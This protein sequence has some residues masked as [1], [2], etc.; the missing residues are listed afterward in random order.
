MKKSFGKPDVTQANVL[1]RCGAVA[2]WLKMRFGIPYI[3]VEHWSRYLPQ[4]F[5]FKGILRKAVSRMAVRRAS[6]IMPVSRKLGD[7]MRGCGLRNDNYKLVN[8][9]ADDFF[10]DTCANDSAKGGIFRF[11]HISCFVERTKNICGI[12]RAVKHLSEERN[13][14]SLTIVGAGPDYDMVKQYADELVLPDGMVTFVGEQPPT[15]VSHF[16]SESGA[17]I[18]FSNYENA[19]VVISESL[20][21]GTPVIATNVG[22]IPDMV[23]E[24]NGFLLNPKDEVALCEKMSW[25]ID[26][27]AEF[28]SELIRRNA[29]RYSYEEVGNFL[30]TV[31][32][33]A[34]SK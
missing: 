23:D 33:E 32:R 25:M 20:A 3:I 18:L 22:G 8:N 27:R 15:N 5:N 11:L 6:C 13:D 9:V 1:T 26:H 10:F 7:A 34:L 30:F 21:T 12:L 2:L 29:H 4:N 31:Y 16:F 14:F 19:P 24:T 28:D 17:F